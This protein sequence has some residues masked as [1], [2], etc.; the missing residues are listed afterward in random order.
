MLNAFDLETDLIFQNQNLLPTKK[1]MLYVIKN[2]FEM[3]SIQIE[4]CLEIGK[5]M[6]ISLK[7]PAVNN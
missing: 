7:I 5:P 4:N 2:I 3:Q 6:C 1:L